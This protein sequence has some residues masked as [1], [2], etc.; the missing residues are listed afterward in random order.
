MNN[1]FDIEDLLKLFPD[2]EVKENIYATYY[3]SQN[4]NKE[5]SD[6]VFQQFYYLKNKYPEMDIKIDSQSDE[7]ANFNSYDFCIYLNGN[8]DEMVFL[9]ELTHFFSYCY[10]KY[11]TPKE[12]YELCDKLLSSKDI[13]SSLVDFIELCRDENIK[14]FMD[15]KANF[16]LE[17]DINNIISK[18]DDLMVI[19]DSMIF[20]TLIAMVEDII[21]A[22]TRGE[23]NSNGLVYIKDNNHNPKKAHKSSGHGCDYFRENG[24]CYEE[25]IANYQAITLMDPDNKLFAILKDILGPDFVSFLDQRLNFINGIEIEK[26]INNNNFKK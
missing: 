16:K 15:F 18:D 24:N 1:M 14:K 22:I 10:S 5:M 3:K 20:F 26:E 9:H 4:S 8:I 7:P 11:E 2:E 19:D 25:I 17:F 6:A 13:I 23:A 21:D 12:Y